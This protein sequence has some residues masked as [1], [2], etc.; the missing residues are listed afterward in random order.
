MMTPSVKHSAAMDAR[1]DHAHPAD[2]IQ[3]T[4][5]QSRRGGAR[6][7]PRSSNAPGEAPYSQL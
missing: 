1:I 6:P 3:D 2:G 7:G 5:T 4:E